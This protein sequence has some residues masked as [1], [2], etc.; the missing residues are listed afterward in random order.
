MANE[1]LTKSLSTVHTILKIMKVFTII[2][3]VA[4]VIVTLAL[5]SLGVIFVE[6]M[7]MAIQESGEVLDAET[8][9]V[10]NGL[11]DG[12]YGVFMI[13]LVAGVVSSVIS[14]M[15][16]TRGVKLVGKMRN[17]SIFAPTYGD[18]LR[19]IGK[20]MIIQFFITLAVTV[21]MTVFYAP[22]MG[23]TTLSFNFNT[24]ITA[25]FVYLA[26]YLMDHAY[27]NMKKDEYIEPQTVYVEPM[28]GDGSEM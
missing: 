13:A 6:V 2:G 15:Y 17:E 5:P 22:E 25:A 8:M 1:K 26:S 18:E 16:I 12:L 27:E 7:N 28:I 4:L 19:G 21:L 3:I 20:F 9:A 24:L 14:Y 11:Q 23:T 10:I